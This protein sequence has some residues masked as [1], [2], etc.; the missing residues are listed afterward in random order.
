MKAEENAVALIEKRSIKWFGNVL[1]IPEKRWSKKVF[2]W[3]TGS[4]RKSE[5][6]KDHGMGRW[7]K[8]WRLATWKTTRSST[9]A[10]ARQYDCWALLLVRLETP[11]QMNDS[12][13]TKS[14]SAS[15]KRAVITCC[16]NIFII[17]KILLYTYREVTSITFFSLTSQPQ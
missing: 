2:E 1:R 16:V 10:A 9:E 3:N 4:R 6:P 14:S 17:C 5:G 7:E 11:Y 13:C 15:V 12:F 8:Q